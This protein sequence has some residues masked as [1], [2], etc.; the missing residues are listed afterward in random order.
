M[1]GVAIGAFGAHGLKSLLLVNERLDVFE[2]A[3]KYQFYHAFALLII[4][5]IGDKIDRKWIRAAIYSMSVGVLIFSG[6]L[7]ILS[8]TNVG[9]WGM[10]TPIG[11]L[12]LIV[13]WFLLLL[14]IVRERNFG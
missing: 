14:G 4:G 13:G 12:L 8:I 2:T 10:V 6:S 11:G 1:L 5:L 7:Y 3:V 9:Y